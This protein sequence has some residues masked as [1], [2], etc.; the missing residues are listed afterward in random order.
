[1]CRVLILDDDKRYAESLKPVV[2]EFEGNGTVTDTA[3]TLNEALGCAQQAVLC[4]QPYTVFIIDQRL[5]PGKDGIE[6]MQDLQ[7]ASPDSDAIILTGIGDHEVGK[8]AYQAG[9]FRYLAK[10]VEEEELTFVLN[11]LMQSRREKLVNKWRKVFSEMMETALHKTSFSEVAKVVVEYSLQLGFSRAHIFWFPKGEKTSLREALTGIECAGG[12]SVSGFSNK[13]FTVSP[14][15]ELWRYLQTRDTSFISP[16][17]VGKKLRSEL[18][19]ID[20]PFPASGLWLLPLWSGTELLGA[21]TLDFWQTQRLLGAQER[22]LLNFFARQVA[23]T[24]EHAELYDAE[25]RSTQEAAMFS[26]IGRQVGTRAATKN[27]TNLLEQIRV[28]VGKLFDVSDFSIFLHDEQENT[29]NFELLYENGT[30]QNK[31]PRLVGNG[32]EE[33]MLAQKQATR[34]NDVRSFIKKNGIKVQGAAPLAW[35]GAPLQVGDKI[36]GGVCIQRWEK[37][38][39]FSEHEK[40]LLRSVA[41]QVAG[42]VQISEL[43]KEEDED[44]ERMQLLQRASME[45]LWIAR[46]SEDDFWLTVLTIATANFGMGFNRALLFLSKENREILQGRAGVG[47]NNTQ[48]A[49]RHWKRDEK[50]K[51]DLTSFLSA[52]EAGEV[53]FTPFHKLARG[54]DISLG[55]L[56]NETREKLETSRIIKI[57]SADLPKHLPASIIQKFELSDCALL[58]IGTGNYISGLVIVDNKHNQKP[59]NDKSLGSLQSLLANAGLVWE[60]LRQREK[61]ED[62][63]DANLEILGWASHQS[64][65]KTLDRICKTAH[66][67]SRA[68]WTI[69][70]PFR[71]GKN[72]LEIEVENVGHYGELKSSILDLTKSNPRIGGISRHVLK[73]GELVVSNI[74]KRTSGVGRLKLSESHFIQS[75]G[76]KALIGVAV[77]DQYTQKALGILY[78]DY[79]QPRE[80]SESDIHHAESLASLAAVAISN[81]HE[82]EEIKQRRQ[83]KLAKDIAEAVGASLNLETT[84]DAILSRLYDTFGK[85]RLCVLLYDKP[86]EALKFA[87]GTSKFYKINNPKY[88]RQNSFPLNGGTIACRVARRTLVAKKVQLDNVK[89]VGK[90]RDY[91]VLNPKVKSEFCISLLSTKNELLGVMAL[92]RGQV[93]GFGGDDIETIKAVA[94]HISIAIER[95]QQSEELE[96]NSTVAAQTSWA[97][98]IA[99]EV[100]NEVG[101]ILNWTYFIRKI[102]VENPQIQEYAKSIEE[103]ASQLSSANPWTSKPPQ[104]VEIDS[105]LKSHLQ[106]STLLRNMEV[107]FDLNAPEALVMI[108]VAQF[109]HIL[110]HLVNN[111]ARAM[112][113]LEKKRI[114]VSTRLAGNKNTV[115][116]L[117]QDSGPGISEEKHT[118]AFRRRFTTKETGGYGLL[119]IR[120][121]VEDMQG[122]IMLMPYQ[123]GK[124][125]TFSIRLPIA[126]STI[127]PGD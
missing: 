90:D 35:L 10:P 32:L 115:E 93:N 120:L 84:M 79:R 77:K 18:A 61:S 36:I 86:M 96:Y 29:L 62:L 15:K 112:K 21:L 44:R 104:E 30:R 125:A 82:I 101:K 94:L 5:G 1:M 75:E 26:H 16:E 53:R 126:N 20:F 50:L 9:A 33:Y 48:E 59:L 74:D 11:S 119:F 34:L 43:K 80:F 89:D 58:S 3:S 91:L 47:T 27:L 105:M 2:D 56:G 7:N 55:E 69:I 68:D 31:P 60:T 72:P 127:Y 103:S 106:N 23:V 57:K 24:L 117:F 78:L 98:N 46:R 45:M 8:R 28:E 109:Q 70:H 52:V 100:N 85:T 41:D 51:K 6:A 123:K 42:A 37:G 76:V 12:D 38:I 107:D 99:H 97:A 83:F 118:S 14:A 54:V 113:E 92:E 49:L 13:K 116:I 108:K 110:R 111:A 73:K 71:A 114:F 95:A 67:I 124:G 40:Q 122:E 22:S 39:T 81:T 121:M 88:S 19:V 65:K 63:L 87:P 66:V 102:A 25:K 17:D 4:G 64:L